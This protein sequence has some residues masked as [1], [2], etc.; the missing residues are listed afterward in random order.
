MV[1]VPSMSA[2]SNRRP[3]TALII[4][5]TNAAVSDHMMRCMN[6]LISGSIIIQQ[7]GWRLVRFGLLLY[8]MFK[9]TL[10]DSLHFL[11]TLTFEKLVNAL[12]VWLSYWVSRLTGQPIYWGAPLSLSIEPTTA[13][14]LG[15]PECPSGLKSFSRST[16]SMRI[17]FAKQVIHAQRKQLMYL[18]FYFQGEPFLN[19]DL[20]DMVAYAASL[21][22]YT[23][24]STNGHFLSDEIA[25]KTVESGLSRLI[26]SIDGSTEETYSAYRKGGNFSAVLE[27]TK[28]IMKWKREL[29]SST[30]YVVI[31]C[32]V[33]RHNEHQLNEMRKLAK[34]L[35]VDAIWFKSAQVYDYQNDPNSLIPENQHYSRYPIH[36]NARRPKN[37][38]HPYC[39]RMWHGNVVTW[40]GKVVPCCFDK[41]ARHPM[42]DLY[43]NSMQEIWQAEPYRL[44][45]KQLMKSR[46]NI[47]I[48]TNCSEG[49][50]VRLEK[51]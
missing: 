6:A 49:L 8:T 33:F 1:C 12:R 32:V 34:E 14:N 44:F 51:S 13:C 7:L 10:F 38:D 22:I 37:A 25:K 15:C 11:S 20:L 47:D 24:T 35:K 16:G 18:G 29:K 5:Q 41:D 46:K 36:D 23:G 17:E 39:W 31:Q 42:G 21:K 40:D 28:R 48:C 3:A 30:P 43:S 50:C 45:R 4:N 19:K 27:G 26:I 9:S 2:N